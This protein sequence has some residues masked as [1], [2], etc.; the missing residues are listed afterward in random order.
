MSG[1]EDRRIKLYSG[2]R[3][4]NQQVASMTS[5]SR[6][7]KRGPMQHLVAVPA[8]CDQVSLRVVTEGASLSNMMNVQILERSTSLAAPTI[9]FQDQPT[10]RRIE[11]RRRSNWR[12]FL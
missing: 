1:L 6:A 10:H 5:L 11:P 9:A 4:L 8:Q 2:F 7:R 3:P 12:P